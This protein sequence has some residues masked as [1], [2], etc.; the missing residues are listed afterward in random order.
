[1]LVPL[2]LTRSNEAAT[3]ET[4]RGNNEPRR[5]AKA[6]HTSP[7]S[8]SLETQAPLARKQFRPGAGRCTCWY[9]QAERGHR[10][11]CPRASCSS[12]HTR[13]GCCPRRDDP[14]QNVQIVLRAR[15]CAR[16]SRRTA[17]RRYLAS[18]TTPGPQA[19][20]SLGV[21][22]CHSSPSATVIT[23]NG[24]APDVHKD[25]PR[26]VGGST[27]AIGCRRGHA[28][29][30]RTPTFAPPCISAPHRRR[31]P[32]LRGKQKAKC[33]FDRLSAGAVAQAGR[34]RAPSRDR[35]EGLDSGGSSG[36]ESTAGPKLRQ[37][38]GGRHGDSGCS[39]P[40]RACRWCGASNTW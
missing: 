8:P 18:E 26:S 37:D 33:R 21:D 38:R 31:A 1:M 2:G 6:L 13:P 28:S 39:R 29:R 36:L 19:N 15:S 35:C 24:C 27:L 32:A 25:R 3:R 17:D 12:N 4:Y 30:S 9:W 20:A 5:R 34:R 23:V 40:G 16:S 11:R 22:R 7:Y 10:R 14:I